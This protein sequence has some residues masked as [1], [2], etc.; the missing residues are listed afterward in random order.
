MLEA[1]AR[2]FHSLMLSADAGLAALVFLGLLAGAGAPAAAP[3]GAGAARLLILGLVASLAWP[4]TLAKLGFYGSNRR[5]AAGWILGRLLAVACVSASLLGAAVLALGAPLP[6]LFPLSCA[7]AQLGALAALRL[8]RFS[9]LRL[10]RRSGRK[11]R[12]VLIVGS[13][14]QARRVTRGIERHPEWG[15]RVVGYVDETD[16]PV[17]PLLRG[18]RIHK[19]HELPRLLSEHAINEVILT[20]PRSMFAAVMPAVTLCAATGVPVT[21][22]ADLFGD[23]LP[24]PRVARFDAQAALCFAPVHHGRLALGLKR[25]LDVVGASLLLVALL[26]VMAVAALVI[27]ATA[28]GPIVFRQIRCGL[29]GRPFVMLKLRTMCEDAEERKRELLPLNEARGPVFKLRRD[30]RV[31]RVGAVLRRWSID[32]L[33]QLWNVLKGDMSLVGPRPPVPLEVAEY[34]PGER[35][36]LSMRPGL[37]CIWQVSG[38]STV[39]FPDWVK[40]DL[41]YIDTWSLAQDLRLLLRTVPAVIRGTGAS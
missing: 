19:L 9:G 6:P 24:P 15:L 16:V 1:R 29:N 18:K 17:D 41:Q 31:T 36:R 12:S 8:A 13:G 22:L 37:T 38:R 40:L 27:R 11:P 26:P 3:D 34:E 35:R 5:A 25:A 32:E 10:L 33:P 4:V 23:V 20:I 2:Q 39:A 7:L 14:A 28:P 21:L 30:P